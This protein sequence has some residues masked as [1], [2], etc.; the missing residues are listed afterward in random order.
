MAQPAELAF[1]SSRLDAVQAEAS[2]RRARDDTEAQ[3]AV[4][5]EPHLL[6]ALESHCRC[7][8]RVLKGGPLACGWSACGCWSRAEQSRNAVLVDDLA[9]LA[10]GVS[11]LDACAHLKRVNQR[12]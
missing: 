7:V 4:I 6:D 9:L 12:W 3:L 10:D 5:A 11:L 8:W 2:T 1:V